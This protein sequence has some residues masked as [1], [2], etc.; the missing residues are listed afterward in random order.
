MTQRAAG[1]VPC[2]TTAVLLSTGSGAHG[3]DF[4]RA[5]RTA[6]ELSRSG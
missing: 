3:C 6:R 1:D 2:A 4:A 5:P